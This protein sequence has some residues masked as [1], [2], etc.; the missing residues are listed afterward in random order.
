[1]SCSSGN[2]ASLERD[3]VSLTLLDPRALTEH[4]AAYPYVCRSASDRGL[5]IAA[6]PRRQPGRVW[7]VGEEVAAYVGEPGER[8]RR[9]LVEW[10]HGHQPA[11]PQH[12]PRGEIGGQVG[13][14]VDGYAGPAGSRV[15]RVQADLD[16]TI[17]LVGAL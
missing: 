4:R 15:R 14:P 17:E 5:Q 12:P 8:R 2:P 6:H 16:Q 9:V 11:Q 13:Q 3:A 10:R 1:M 7:V